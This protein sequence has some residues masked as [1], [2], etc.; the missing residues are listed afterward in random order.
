MKQ[1]RGKKFFIG[2]VIG[3]A[4]GM[5]FSNQSRTGNNMKEISDVLSYMVRENLYTHAMVRA[6]ASCQP[7]IFEWYPFIETMQTDFPKWRNQS[8]LALIRLGGTDTDRNILNVF[9]D[10]KLDEIIKKYGEMLTLWRIPMDDFEHKSP[11]QELIDMG[12]RGEIIQVD[13]TKSDDISP[14]GD[15]PRKE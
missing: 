14:Y 6:S 11:E 10:E 3:A 1:K 8:E 2:A 15:L 9:W 13:S 5:V 4:T 12:F 7:Y